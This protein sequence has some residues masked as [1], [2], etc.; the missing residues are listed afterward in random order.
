MFSSSILTQ[1]KIFVMRTAEF[2]GD[3]VRGRVETTVGRIIF[4]SKIPQDL[5]FIDRTKEENALKYEIDVKVLIR[6]HN[7]LETLVGSIAAL[8]DAVP[9]HDNGLHGV[10]AAPVV[11]QFVPHHQILTMFLLDIHT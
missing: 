6:H 5:G 3:I 8:V 1:A 7:A 11:E 2:E 4:N 9:S 10:V